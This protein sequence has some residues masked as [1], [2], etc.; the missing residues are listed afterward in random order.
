MKTINSTKTNL[1]K[2][3]LLSTALAVFLSSSAFADVNDT[4]EKTFDLD[5]NGR[6]E[7]SN[8]NGDVTISAC[9]CSQVTLT[10]NITASSQEIRDRISIEIADSAS[11]LKVKTKYKKQDNDTHSWKKNSRNHGHSEVV[12]HLTVPNEAKLSDI[13]LVN[14]D[15]KITGISG[16]LNDDLVNGSLESDGLTASTKVN[17]VNGNMKLRFESLDNAKN[18]ELEAVNGDIEIYLPASADAT[19]NAE[20]VSGRI[21]NEFGIEVIKHKYVGSEMSGSIGGGDI[22]IDLEN[23]NGRIA[24]KML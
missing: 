13:D 20:T 15:L 4:I 23:V 1:K 12:Y 11:K 24:V 18:I 16:H 6:I 5:S 17:M 22:Q 2:Y 10:A 8:I 21:S 7:L 3:S 19:V 14:G 9:D